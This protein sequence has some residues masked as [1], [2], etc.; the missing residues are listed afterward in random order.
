MTLSAS[1][2]VEQ[3][4]AGNRRALARLIS[5]AENEHPD[6]VAA[7]AALYPHTGHA[8]TIGVTG[9]PGTGKSVLVTTLTKYL[10]QQ[11]HTVAIVA[12]DPSSPFTGG[13]VLG[14]RFRMR[15]L[16]GD[17]GVFIRS[18]ATRGQLGGLA[19]TTA[20]VMR[21][22]DAAGF[23]Y[24][25][26]ETVGAGQN[27]VEIAQIADTTV[28]VEAPGM[29]DDI[30][31]IKAGILEIA[32]VIAVN[33]ADHPGVKNTVR[34]LKAMLELG[35]RKRVVV[36]HGQVMQQN[37]GLPEVQDD[38]W[39]V[40]VVETIALKDEGIA[41]LEQAIQKHRTYLRES[42]TQAEKN[43]LR[44]KSELLQRLREALLVDLL[45]K[46]PASRLETTID[47]MLER[48]VDPASAVR[49]LLNGA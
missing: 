14:D 1:S 35:H 17:S 36:H 45:Q 8:Y 41:A 21:I 9:A 47:Q 3:V 42:G 11:E 23:D 29:G 5:L 22:L 31:A 25:I 44:L 7:L 48:Q 39:M 40:P 33:K 4:L 28:L 20:D 34:A 13:A 26:V 10:R 38:F 43:R 46:T 6:S 16:S 24:V 2:L 30:Q 18:M 49:Q 37:D 27:E 32:D 15:D 12:V 19:R